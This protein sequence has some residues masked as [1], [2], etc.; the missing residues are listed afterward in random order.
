MEGAGGWAA[1]DYMKGGWVDKR[2]RAQ[3]PSRRIE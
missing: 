1:N 2:T 3:A